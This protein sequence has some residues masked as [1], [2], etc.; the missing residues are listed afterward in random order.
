E[1]ELTVVQHL[2]EQLNVSLLSLVE[3]D[4]G[5]ADLLTALG[6]SEAAICQQCGVACFADL[7]LEASFGE[8]MARHSGELS[9]RM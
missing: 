8:L 6:R 1:S 7:Q 2:I 3:S 9:K 4:V 5:L